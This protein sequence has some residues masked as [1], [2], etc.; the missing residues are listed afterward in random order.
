[1][2]EPRFTSYQIACWSVGAG[3]PRQHDR[4]GIHPLLPDCLRLQSHTQLGSL[5]G[6]FS[7]VHALGSLPLG[8][9]A[10]RVSRKKVV[11]YS[12]LFWSGATFLSG[13][14]GSFRALVA[15]R[16]L[17]GVGEAAYTPAGTAIIT[18]SFPRRLRARVQ[19]VFDTGMFLGGAG[20]IALG[21]I[22]AALGMAVRIFV[23]EF[24]DSAGL[25]RLPDVL[26]VKRVL[27]QS[28]F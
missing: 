22:I 8:W 25:F 10:D 15:A 1:M 17:V 27:R 20:G 13:I 9:L 2:A 14:A 5:A 21:G 11:S 24:R 23:V 26:Q 28:R 7:L 12:V 4:Q 18:A 16:A 19:G 6:A 3:Q